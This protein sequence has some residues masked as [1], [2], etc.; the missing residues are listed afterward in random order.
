MTIP[1]SELEETRAAL[2]PTLEATAA[3]LP[4]LAKPREPRFPPALAERWQEACGRLAAAW[5]NRHGAGFAA[6]RPAVF[7]LYGV[8]L[9]LKDTD[10]LRLA[11]A[12][13]TASD[14]LDDPEGLTNQRLVAALS[15]A[16]ECLSE[17]GGLEH[18][19]FPQRARHFAAR[20]ERAAA[21][22]AGRSPVLDRLFADE[23]G[24]CLERMRSALAAL[25]PDAY[26]L[27]EAAADLARLAEVLELDGIAASAGRLVR[28]LTLRAGESFDLEAPAARR[29]ALDLVAGLEA[30]IAAVV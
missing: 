4:W 10:C 16:L 30:A 20:L 13:T 29:S 24:E 21:G 27:K 8:A 17:P 15:A 9:E 22:D 25:P 11:E 3:I 6:L 14:R 5:S 23:A 2:A 28:L 19:V 18:E 7:G 1:E 26:A 12:L